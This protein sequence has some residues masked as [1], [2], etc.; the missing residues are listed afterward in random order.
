MAYLLEPVGLSESDNSVYLA[1]VACPKASLAELADRLRTPVGSVRRAMA[2]LVAAGLVTKMLTRPTRY[3][4]APPDAAVEALIVRRQRELQDLCI[5]A[6][7]LALRLQ[8]TPSPGPV[9]LV[10]LIEGRD[11]IQGH[12]DRTQANA[13]EEVLIIDAPPYLQG[14]PVRNAGE[15]TNLARGVRHRSIYHRPSLEE[16]GH[17]DQLVECVRAGEQART[18]I[19]VS[20]K[21]QIVDREIAIIPV[22]FTHTETFTRLLVH[23][24][25]M[26]DALVQCFESLWHQAVPV[27]MSA[28]DAVAPTDDGDPTDRDRALLTLLATGMKDRAIA[29]TLGIT[30]R[31]LSR[32]IRELMDTLEADTRFQAGIQAAQLGWLRTQE[33]SGNE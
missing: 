18:L 31:T 21:M 1:L 27:A 14:M 5:A 33:S 8:D 3:L 32:H 19:S 2:R 29:K 12:L 11:V 9:G 6:S 25:P 24:S 4:P 15:L 23:A 30:E 20:M 13:R 10:E 28:G 7:E 16:P 17:F 26:L 22:S